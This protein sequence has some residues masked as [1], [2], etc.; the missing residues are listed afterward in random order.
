MDIDVMVAQLAELTVFKSRVMPMLEAFEAEQAAKRDTG[1]HER[2]EDE[3]E[4]TR[5]RETA[6]GD[7]KDEPRRDES[8]RAAVHPDAHRDARDTGRGH[9][10]RDK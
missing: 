6:K 9:S 2:S 8:G 3:H 4:Q 5:R 10:G 1:D 7:D